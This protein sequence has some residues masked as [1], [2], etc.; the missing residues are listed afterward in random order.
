MSSPQLGAAGAALEDDE[1]RVRRHAIYAFQFKYFFHREFDTEYADFIE[2]RSQRSCTTGLR[3]Q[4]LTVQ[5]LSVRSF[6]FVRQP[7][8]R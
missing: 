4:A 1:R 6:K 5:T 7:S 8:S 2:E 3:M